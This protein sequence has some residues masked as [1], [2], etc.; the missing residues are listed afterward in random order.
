MKR[1]QKQTGFTIVELLVVI[2]VIAILAAITIV[3]FNGI[4]KQA[5][6]TKIKN[7]IAVITRAITAARSAETKTLAQITNSTASGGNCWS[8][9]DGTNLATLDKSDG[10]WTRY[11][12]TLTAIGAA[13]NTNLSGLVD[14]W[15][16]PYLIDENEGESGGCNS[17]TVSVYR[18][19][20]VTGFGVYTGLSA[21][22]I[23]RSGFSGCA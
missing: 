16:R 6:D 22:N 5:Q 23:T 21:N 12:Q 18:Q 11:Y 13:A 7:D 4:Q 20:F 10:C 2:V 15:G 1:G 9:A 14:S 8:K 3:S 19:P 17:D